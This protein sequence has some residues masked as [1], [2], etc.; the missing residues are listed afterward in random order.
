MKVMEDALVIL[1]VAVRLFLFVGVVWIIVREI[2]KSGR[3]P[4]K[5]S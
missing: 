4:G 2:R 3:E 5:R 1:L